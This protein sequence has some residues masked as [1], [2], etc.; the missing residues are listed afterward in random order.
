MAEV[1]IYTKTYCPFSKECKKMLD[2]K[3]VKYDEK[4]IDH[5]PAIQKEMETKS[6]ERT[7]TPQVFVSISFW[8][9]GS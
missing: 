7:D 4:V 1:I 9:A 8:I 5:D 3:G 6:G 2:E